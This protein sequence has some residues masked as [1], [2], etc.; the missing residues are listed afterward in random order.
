MSVRLHF[1]PQSSE[2]S[3]ALYEGITYEKDKT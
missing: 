2:G 1:L 3:Q